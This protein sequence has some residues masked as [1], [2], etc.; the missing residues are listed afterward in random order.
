M[1]TI[2]LDGTEEK[3]ENSHKKEGG[4]LCEIHKIKTVIP[5]ILTI[6]PSR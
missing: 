4:K 3:K 2:V 6:L 5:M 1:G